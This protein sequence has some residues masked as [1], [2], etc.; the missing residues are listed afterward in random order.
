[1]RV[2]T[3]LLELADRPDNPVAPLLPGAAAPV[4]QIKQAAAGTAGG[5]SSQDPK[6]ISLFQN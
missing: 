1:L 2:E 4:G 3:A 6:N 5:L